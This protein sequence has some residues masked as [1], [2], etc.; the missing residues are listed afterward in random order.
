M[1]RAGGHLWVPLVQ[2]CARAGPPRPCHGP[3]VGDVERETAGDRRR[4]RDSPEGAASDT[5]CHQP[6]RCSPTW[7]GFPLSLGGKLS[8][9]VQ[10]LLPCSF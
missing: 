6:H 7:A 8:Q 5:W 9:A 1:G 3:S 2:P 10:K 4:G